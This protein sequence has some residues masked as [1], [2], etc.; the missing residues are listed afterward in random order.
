M[1]QINGRTCDYLINKPNLFLMRQRSFDFIQDP[2]HGWIKVRMSFLADLFGP[3]W[4][5]HFTCCSYEKGGFVYLEEDLDATTFINR[6]KGKDISFKFRD[7]T[8]HT[9]FSRIRNYSPLQPRYGA[10]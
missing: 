1:K 7:R 4:R 6:L 8:C 2:G 5:S 3:R 10:V 9:R